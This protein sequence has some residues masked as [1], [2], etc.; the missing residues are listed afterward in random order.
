VDAIPEILLVWIENG[1]TN[2]ES[3]HP[4]SIFHYRSPENAHSLSLYCVMKILTFESSQ[5]TSDFHAGITI[6]S[7]TISMFA[8]FTPIRWI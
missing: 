1:S 2:E 7:T 6:K 3:D 4:L 8:D 5:R